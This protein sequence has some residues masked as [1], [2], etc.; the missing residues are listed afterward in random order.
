[1][2][3]GN[4]I[5]PMDT[6]QKNLLQWTKLDLELKELNKKCSDI[7]KKKDILQSRI[8]PIIHSENLED[9]IFS[10][11]ALQT[12]V[13]LKE[14]KSSESLSYKFLE[15]KLNDYFDTPEKGGLLI[16]YLKDNR[17]AETSFILKSNHLI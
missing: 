13:L 11:P 7:R 14:Q 15:E 2:A 10:I 12:N 5:Q 9:N 17:K 16:Q 3:S 1:M 8:C 4:Y 6:L